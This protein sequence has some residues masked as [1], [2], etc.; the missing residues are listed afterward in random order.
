ML[1]SMLF[2]LQ[3]DEVVLQ[4]REP[5]PANPWVE[6]F[7]ASCGRQR[8][9]IRRPMRPHE[10]SP[11]VLLNGHRPR[12]DVAS[13]EAELG[14]VGAAYRMSFLCSPDGETIKFRWVSGL[15]QNGGQVDYRAGSAEFHLG[16]MARS[17]SGESNEET[18]WY[19]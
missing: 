2:A 15:V 7:N 3:V 16:A 8:L 4:I 10:S 19:R 18:F 14:E 9:E 5:R 1:L 11:Q 17:S 12:G 13:L 6:V